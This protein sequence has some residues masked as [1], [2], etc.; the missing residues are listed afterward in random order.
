MNKKKGLYRYDLADGRIALSPV[1]LEYA[2]NNKGLLC[3]DAVMGNDAKLV[4]LIADPELGIL[5]SLSYQETWE[6]PDKVIPMERQ[7]RLDL[8]YHQNCAVMSRGKVYVRSGQFVPL[9]E[10]LKNS[11]QEELVLMLADI[12]VQS[13]L[14]QLELAKSNPQGASNDE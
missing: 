1:C 3:L 5:L 9:Q 14:A 2:C 11:S 7:G 8:S 12:A 4:N 10:Y 13:A 6:S